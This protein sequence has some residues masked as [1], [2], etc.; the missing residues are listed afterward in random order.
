[1]GG[2][3][4]GVTEIC[5]CF[6]LG[7]MSQT[8]MRIQQLTSPSLSG[9]SLRLQ[10]CCG[11]GDVLH[12]ACLQPAE[13]RRHQ[14][15]LLPHTHPCWLLLLPQVWW[16]PSLQCQ[17]HTAGN[18]EGENLCEFRGFV[19]IQKFFSTNFGVVTFFGGKRKQSTQVFI[20][21]I[22]FSTNSQKFSPSKVSRYMV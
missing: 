6:S 18:L 17:Y 1:M 21:K 15:P 14:D 8:L 20:M 5:R 19:A 22:V 13:R 12:E 11:P 4:V 10:W 2:E 16:H 9:R 3:C 7:G